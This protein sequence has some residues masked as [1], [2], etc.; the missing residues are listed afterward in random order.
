MPRAGDQV[1]GD[2]G[3]APARG[4]G[5][6]AVAAGGQLRVRVTKSPEPSHP[7]LSPARMIGARTPSGGPAQCRQHV[8]RGAA[9]AGRHRRRSATA[10]N[11]IRAQHMVRGCQAAAMA[12][13]DRAAGRLTPLCGRRKE[14]HPT[15]SPS[16]PFL[17]DIHGKRGYIGM[18][19]Q[20]APHICV[21][22]SQLRR[23]RVTYNKLTL[24]PPH[25]GRPCRPTPPVHQPA[26]PAAR[27]RW[28][29]CSTATTRGGAHA[30]L[31][32]R[33]APREARDEGLTQRPSG[34][35][36]ERVSP[37]LDESR[38]GAGSGISALKQLFL[39][40]YLYEIDNSI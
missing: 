35:G 10:A 20:P 34:C 5:R 1:L 3:S 17:F 6:V 30:C 33:R 37:S 32:A 19:S 11:L 8:Q 31:S 40:V 25:N 13:P 18:C 14:P 7:R 27:S 9:T 15:I 26:L 36:R 38:Q 4:I 29:T 21:V 12:P 23:V 16:G 22:A 39:E 24:M 2:R 28:V